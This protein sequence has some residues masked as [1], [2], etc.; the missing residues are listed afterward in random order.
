MNRG[1]CLQRPEPHEADLQSTGV[2]IVRAS[3]N[4][5]SSHASSSVGFGGAG[6]GGGD[7][8]GSSDGGGGLVSV[9][10]DDLPPAPPTLTRSASL[11]LSQLYDLLGPL[12]AAFHMVYSQQRELGGSGRDFVGMRDYYSM[13]RSH[14]TP[15][16]PLSSPL[17]PLSSSSSSSMFP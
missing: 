7:G 8:D 1:V 12:A 17:P 2:A 4:A 6:G 14:A 10:S 16:Y 11:P 3:P 5:L 15:Q 13:V 9:G